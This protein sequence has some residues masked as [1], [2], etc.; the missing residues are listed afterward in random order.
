LEALK[1]YDQK[2]KFEDLLSTGSYP[3]VFLRN[4]D[5]RSEYLGKLPLSFIEQYRVVV[6]YKKTDNSFALAAENPDDTALHKAIKSLENANKINFQIFATSR[7]DIDYAIEAY[8]KK[9][10]N[11][12]ENSVK[13][14]VEEEKT[15]EKVIEKKQSSG[16]EIITLSSLFGS[17]LGKKEP[18]SQVT[19]VIRIDSEESGDE[20]ETIVAPFGAQPG[21]ETAAVG[22]ITAPEDIKSPTKTESKTG[23]G[24]EDKTAG[25]NGEQPSD[26]PDLES[27]TDISEIAT[28]ELEKNPKTDESV[29]ESEKNIGAYLKGDIVDVEGLKSNIKNSSAP[30][31]VAALINFALFERASDIHIEP[32]QKDLRVRYR[33]D[34]ILRDIIRLPL[35][36][37][38]PI[39]SRVKILSKLKIDETRVPQD[40]RFD[41]T[42]KNR[43]V[44][45]RVSSLPTVH[46]EKIVMR[47]LDKDQGILSLEDLGMIG[48]GFDLTIEAIG[49]PFGIILSTGPTGSGKSTTL[50]AIINR[51]SKPSVNIVTLED[52]VEYEING[53][54]QCQV[55]PGIGFSFA[56]GLRS[57][58]R[59]D[60]NVVMVGEIRDGETAEMATHAALTGHLVLSTLHT[61]DASGAL[62]RFTNMGIEPFLI[63]SSINIIIAQRLVRRICP[64]CKEEMKVPQAF[65]E[66]V[67]KEL[68]AISAQNEQDK[69]RIPSEFKFYHGV[70]CSNCS[71]GYVGRIGIFEVLRMTDEIEALTVEKRPA[72]EIREAALKDGMI[73]MKQDG[74]L[75]ALEGLTTIDEVFRATSS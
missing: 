66:E 7:E 31:I 33:I 63:T 43:E 62:P 42:F 64:K 44:D 47:I 6:F 70:G 51:I 16:D 4:Q 50:Y 10:E 15:K 69:K 59:Q 39:T 34:G 61:N 74:I 30:K 36:L 52:P 75:K 18:V 1:Q 41:V 71:Q 22:N 13:V 68:S 26:N 9:L 28:E 46:G 57:V 5:I 24:V 17:F 40:G 14:E 60:P 25:Q 21:G 48:R 3:T 27:K 58:L 29:E 55:K 54:N 32:E 53:V 35:S 2:G 11:K 8:K 72:N 73:T 19:P 38:P 56:E 12:K 65:I 23:D 45:V 20:K 37:H 67:K 49:K